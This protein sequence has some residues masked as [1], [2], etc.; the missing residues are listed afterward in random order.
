MEKSKSR[1]R[2]SHRGDGDGSGVSGIFRSAFMGVGAALVSMLVMAVISSGLCMLSPDPASLTLP[3]GIVIFII[4]SAVGGGISATG[5]SK[6]K[7][8]TL[9]SGIICGFAIM[10]FLG[11]GAVT[12]EIISPDS[13]HKI[14]LMTSL[15]IRCAAIP[16][17]GLCA[18]LA[19]LPRKKRRRKR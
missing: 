3:V 12:Q 4:S 6:D 10:T 18:Y 7:T 2:R 5:L 9:F 14:G 16:V 13:T 15:L 8:A 17:S 11:V 19:A 1:K